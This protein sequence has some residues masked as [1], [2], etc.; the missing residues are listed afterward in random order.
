[1]VGKAHFHSVCDG[2]IFEF[3]WRPQGKASIGSALLARGEK[4]EKE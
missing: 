1:M 4:I 3:E 2:E